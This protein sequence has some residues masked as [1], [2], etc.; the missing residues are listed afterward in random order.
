MDRPYMADNCDQL[1]ICLTRTDYWGLR[2]ELVD[3]GEYEPWVIYWG[4][5]FRYRDMRNVSTEEAS[6]G[7][8]Q[9]S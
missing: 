2:R 8:G 5:Y 6:T 9:R 4:T 7:A 1:T 3:A